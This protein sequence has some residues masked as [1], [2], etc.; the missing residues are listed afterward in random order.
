MTDIQQVANDTSELLVN[1]TAILSTYY[2]MFYNPSPMDITLNIYDTSGNLT[3]VTVPNRAK[4]FNFMLKGNGMP[5]SMYVANIGSIYQDILNGSI[6]IK[7]DTSLNTGWS[8]LISQ[9]DLDSYIIKGTGSPE[10]NIT[11]SRGQLYIDTL[12]SLIYV[13]T[14]ITGNTGWITFGNISSDGSVPFTSEIL[15]IDPITPQGLATKNYVDNTISSAIS[16]KVYSTDIVG[17]NISTIPPHANS[18]SISLGYCADS[19]STT[20]IKLLSNIVK[21][22]NDTWQEGTGNGIL[23]QGTSKA[24][25]TWYTIYLISKNNGTVDAIACEITQQLVLP[26]D[27][28][29]YRRIGC[30]E[31]IDYIGLSG[32]ITMAT[33]TQIKNRFYYQ[34]VVNDAT[35]THS[36]SIT[37]VTISIPPITGIIALLNIT[38]QPSSTSGYSYTGIGSAQSPLTPYDN[39]D[40]NIQ[41]YGSTSC[42]NTNTVSLEIPTDT[43]QIS[44]VSTDTSTNSY[45]YIKTIGWVDSYL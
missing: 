20:Y 27:Y 26:Q 34:G 22:F 42:N 45:I 43:G 2:D 1:Y 38:D 39:S 41:S 15:G 19:T 14:T 31:S 9:S 3:A 44:I 33:F 11:S 25:N 23:M 8:L 29:H 35:V 18:V 36:P 17:L 12:N 13:K 4:D 24:N 7:S 32:N 6:Y 10:G 40:S 30:I 5:N 37:D 16:S 21:S 28:T